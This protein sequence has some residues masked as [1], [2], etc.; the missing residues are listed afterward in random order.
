[1][2]EITCASIHQSASDF[3]TATIIDGWHRARGWKG[4]GYHRVILCGR[5]VGGGTVDHFVDGMIQE[6][7]PLDQIPAAVAG[8]NTGMLAVCLIGNG[9]ALPIG[10]GYMSPSMWESLV[11]LC[12]K[13]HREFGVPVEKFLGHREFPDVHKTCPGFAV[14]AL[15]HELQRRLA[16]P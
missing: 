13:W 6:G 16:S 12:L 15:R 3:G 10:E 14:S 2:R 4:I 9:D 5:L 7:R 8:H 11:R 1:M